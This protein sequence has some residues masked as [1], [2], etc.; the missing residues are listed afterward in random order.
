MWAGIEWAY[1]AYCVGLDSEG[2]DCVGIVCVGRNRDAIAG[3]GID[4]K[5]GHCFGN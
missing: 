3:V 4:L 2:I 5:C 1:L